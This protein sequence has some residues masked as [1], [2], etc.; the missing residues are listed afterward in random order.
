MRYHWILLYG[1]QAGFTSRTSSFS[2]G[3]RNGSFPRIGSSTGRWILHRRNPPK[4]DFYICRVPFPNDAPGNPL[5]MVIVHFHR[6]FCLTAL[7]VHFMGD[8]LHPGSRPIGFLACSQ[9]FI[10]FKC[11]EIAFTINPFPLPLAFNSGTSCRS[12]EVTAAFL[13]LDNGMPD[14]L[15]SSPGAIKQ[16]T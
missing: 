15:Q 1:L 16:D 4:L 13:N 10:Y 9:L 2:G 11:T 14:L 8:E 5:Y 12:P 7:L 3:S 6:H